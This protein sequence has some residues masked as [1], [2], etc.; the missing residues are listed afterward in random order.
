MAIVPHEGGI[1]STAYSQLFQ[2]T[3][4]LGVRNLKSNVGETEYPHFRNPL[5]NCALKKLQNCD[6]C[7]VRTLSLHKKKLGLPVSAPTHL[8]TVTINLG[9]FFHKEAKITVFMGSFFSQ[10][11]TGS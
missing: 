7:L 4:F 5:R 10:K 1:F 9:V 2:E 11:K 3:I 8:S 6:C